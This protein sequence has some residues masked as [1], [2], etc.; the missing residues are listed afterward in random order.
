MTMKKRDLLF[1]F[2]ILAAISIAW[3]TQTAQYSI[4]KSIYRS[5]ELDT[6]SLNTATSTTDAI[7][8]SYHVSGVIYI[9]TGSSITSLTYYASYDGGTTYLPLQEEVGDGTTRAC[10]RTV[11]AAKAYELPGAPAGATHIKITTNA[12]GTAYVSLKS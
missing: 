12:A 2:A 1:V 5:G 3:T 4:T 10:T 9:P 8:L 7:V 11:A 6:V